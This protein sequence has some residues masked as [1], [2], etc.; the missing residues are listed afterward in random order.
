MTHKEFL[1]SIEEK[2]EKFKSAMAHDKCHSHCDTYHDE[3][4]ILLQTI[5]ENI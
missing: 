4:E 3:I 1:K 5:K 2:I